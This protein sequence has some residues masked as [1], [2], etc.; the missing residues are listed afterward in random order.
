MSKQE[1]EHNLS[2]DGD[3]DGDE[4]YPPWLQNIVEGEYYNAVKVIEEQEDNSQEGYARCKVIEVPDS[5]DAAEKQDP[6]DI[7]KY[8]VKT[9]SIVMIIAE[10][11]TAPYIG[12][13]EK[14]WRDKCKKPLE[15]L[16]DTYTTSD[17]MLECYWFYRPGEVPETAW[18]GM[19]KRKNFKGAQFAF[20]KRG[21][22]Q[23]EKK[24]PRQLLFS[25]HHTKHDYPDSNG[26]LSLEGFL[27]TCERVNWI[28]LDEPLPVRYRIHG[29]KLIKV[30][31][32]G[33]VVQGFLWCNGKDDPQLDDRYKRAYGLDQD[34]GDVATM[35]IVR[36]M[37]R[38]SQ[39]RLELLANQNQKI[40][41][42]YLDFIN[43]KRG[44]PAAA[45][46]RSDSDGPD[47]KQQPEP[48]APPPPPAVPL[49]ERQQRPPAL[50]PPLATQK[51]V[52]SYDDV[53]EEDVPL[54]KLRRLKTTGEA[55]AARRRATSGGEAR[56]PP[57]SGSK[58]D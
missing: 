18:Q 52:G 16:P 23:L 3:K 21:K 17:F 28:G 43:K 29:S 55:S 12:L 31:A 36:E 7:R 32:P 57:T 13:V 41:N 42:K 50:Q 53:S 25:S 26:L 6:S 46:L 24:S 38:K 37:V 56:K 39:R 20:S 22:P 8:E 45:T 44:I 15:G 51:E 2:D 40:I 5:A 33:F 47:D 54:N 1:Q 34:W 49:A 35:T 19:Q 11:D 4:E 48:P 9:H 27:Q 10:P 14:I 30:L 58:P